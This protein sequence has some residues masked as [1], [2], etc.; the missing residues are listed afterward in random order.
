MAD[1]CLLGGTRYL[2]QVK[3]P[4]FYRRIRQYLI[5]Q[6]ERH[7]ES[8]SKKNA[9]D[10]FDWKKLGVGSVK[11]SISKEITGREAVIS[12]FYDADA[13]RNHQACIGVVFHVP[14]KFRKQPPT[15]YMALHLADLLVHEYN[16]KRQARKRGWEPAP[17]PLP[18]QSMT[19]DKMVEYLASTDEIDSYAINIADEL[20]DHRKA[21]RQRWNNLFTKTKNSSR[22]DSYSD[23]LWHYTQYFTL[24]DEVTRRLMKKIYKRYQEMDKYRKAIKK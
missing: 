1:M 20:Y 13:D 23:Q 17:E 5:D 15:S 14:S 18:Y 6:Y 3:T 21:F 16:H 24:E 19:D 12:G 11:V 9:W 10:W 4:A 8:N 22:E 2:E 7:R